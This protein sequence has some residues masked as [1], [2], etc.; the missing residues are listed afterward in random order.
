[1]NEHSMRDAYDQALRS[2]DTAIPSAELPLDRLEALVSREGSEAERLRALDV[3]MSS[4][5]GRR[6]FE[7]AWAAA[8]AARAPK[9]RFS[10][11]RFAATAAALVFSVSLG[12]L[13][14]E[15]AQ[16]APV[17]ETLRGAESP[18]K[19]ISP[20]GGQ[21]R[22]SG[23]RFAWHRVTAAREYTLVIVDRAGN[24]VFA[25]STTDTAI[26]LPDS[27][28]LRTNSEYLWWVQAQMTDGSQLSAVTETI[29]VFSATR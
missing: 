24:E 27:I 12:L 8:R 28:V 3:A 26:Q 29:K 14:Q 10:V 21:V 5:E 17:T 22:A 19:L 13:W 2:R 18:I 9:K 16:V 4:A 20:R 25:S 6:E 7:I 15:R 11:P 1:V 23:E